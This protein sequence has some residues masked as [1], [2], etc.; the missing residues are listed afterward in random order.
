MSRE[1]LT[2]TRG[3]Y[4]LPYV[5]ALDLGLLVLTRAGVDLLR[6][7]HILMPASVALAIATVALA[8]ARVLTPVPARVG[9]MA[10]LLVF[11]AG[12]LGDV[13]EA[14]R[15]AAQLDRIGGEPMLVTLYA[16]ALAG[17][18]LVLRRGRTPMHE[19][20]RFIRLSLCVLLGM[21]AFQLIRQSFTHA[22]PPVQSDIQVTGEARRPLP[23]I[24]LLVM[25][26][27]TG[28]AP[29]SQHYDLDLAPFE[30]WLRS[31]GFLL[32]VNQRTN[33]AQTFLVLSSLLNLRYLDDY[34]TRFGSQA[35]SRLLASPDIENN[36][37]VAFLKARGYRF[38]FVPSAFDVTRRNR[39]A[40]L[41]VP[42]PADVLA[43]FPVAWYRA[44]AFPV[45][46]RLAC[47]A[48]GCEATRW[49]YVSES[50]EELDRKFTQLGAIP[51]SDQ[52][53]FVFAHLLL[54]HEPY[55]YRSDCSHRPAYWPEVD[56]GTVAPVLREL[57]AE[58]I[59]CTNT[60]LQTLID[61]IQR[62][63]TVP[64][65]I[66]IQGDHGHGRMGHPVF[67]LSNLVP[68]E[69]V[70]E[71]LTPFAAYALPGL[72]AESLPEGI[73]PVNVMRLVLRHY[74]DADLPSLPDRSYWSST[75]QPFAFTEVP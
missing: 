43:D 10:V 37:L 73:T 49:P 41:Q 18:I 45:L 40:D 13:S 56:T 61:A 9:A 62:R 75:N 53:T 28:T 60:K 5:A 66:L 50:A 20:E 74:L 70:D 14:L 29:L 8:G 12:T 44:S 34:P 15:A 17:F 65:V 69:L 30:T 31:R 38:V 1:S 72:P 35:E 68:K 63:A 47:R 21:A 57:Y 24:Y 7:S 58:Q 33:Y 42:E 51:P 4:L 26:K 23:D 22:P 25:D 46:H 52:P 6:L 55:L 54:P 19:G 27:Y 36:R 11:G 59:G 71:R 67:P 48:L 2:S 3:A 64:P 16:L 32:P 39:Y